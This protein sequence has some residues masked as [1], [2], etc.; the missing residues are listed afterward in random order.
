[1]ARRFDH[2]TGWPAKMKAPPSPKAKP[3]PGILSASFFGPV[4]STIEARLQRQI[5]LDMV[6]VVMGGEDI[7][8]RPAAPL[9]CMRGSAAS[10]GASIDAVRPLSGSCISTPKLSLRR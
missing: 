9:E 4:I 8:E 6:L 3:R 5:G 1:M 2:L 10:S 7:G